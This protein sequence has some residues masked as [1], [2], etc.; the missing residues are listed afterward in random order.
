M[1][2]GRDQHAQE[3]SSS[4]FVETLRS[5]AADSTMRP[6]DWVP[7]LTESIFAASA[8]LKGMTVGQ[9]YG[10]S[11]PMLDFPLWAWVLPW[12]RRSPQE[13]AKRFPDEVVRNRAQNGLAL[14]REQAV[15]MLEKPSRSFAESHARQYAQLARSI[16]ENGALLDLEPLPTVWL[17]TDGD[18]LR[19]VM[20]NS[21]NHRA[22]I[23]AAFGLSSFVGRVKGLIDVRQVGRWHGV[24]SGIFRRDEAVLIFERYLHAVPFLKPS[25]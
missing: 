15:I 7:E 16:K 23:Y 6:D 22:R 20:G 5:L 3:F 10:F 1:P 4:G 24:R 14:S 13:H 12:E 9:F 17:L 25:K 2:I 18:S 19:W 21:G 11:S 8:E